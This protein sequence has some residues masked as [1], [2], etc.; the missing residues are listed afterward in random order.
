MFLILYASLLINI[1]T[2]AVIICNAYGM[3]PHRWFSLLHTN[4]LTQCRLDSSATATVELK[5]SSFFGV[6][7]LRMTATSSSTLKHNMKRKNP[8]AKEAQSE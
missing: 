8:C 1:P 3:I 7:P 2:L 4:K 6:H 5:L